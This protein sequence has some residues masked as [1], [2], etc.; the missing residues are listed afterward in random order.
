MKKLIVLPQSITNILQRALQC[1][2]DYYYG[3][4]P[5]ETISNNIHTHTHI[6]GNGN[7]YWHRDAYSLFNDETIDL[8]LPPFYYTML[9]PL[10]NIDEYSGGTEFIL[11][12]HKTNLSRMNITTNNNLD[13]WINENPD[14]R[15]IPKLNIGDV[16]LFHGYPLNDYRCYNT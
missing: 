1:E 14:K 16:C 6:D 15:Y 8:S 11:G 2:Y 12:S 5:I 13:K 7:G 3:G 4:L 10:D 9:I